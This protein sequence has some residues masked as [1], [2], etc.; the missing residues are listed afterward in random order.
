MSDVL[1]YSH[2]RVFSP[3]CT[4]HTA[5]HPSLQPSNT[6][7]TRVIAVRNVQLELITLND[8]SVIIDS[9]IIVKS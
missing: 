5:H 2:F 7:I 8:C 3:D 4:L 1:P 6:V 9:C